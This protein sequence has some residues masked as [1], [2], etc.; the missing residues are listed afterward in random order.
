MSQFPLALAVE[1]RLLPYAVA[2]GFSLDPKVNL[3]Q[4]LLSYISLIH[5]SS[6]SFSTGTSYFERCSSDPHHRARPVRKMLLRV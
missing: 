4:G 6:V 5:T 2:N 3:I 1:P